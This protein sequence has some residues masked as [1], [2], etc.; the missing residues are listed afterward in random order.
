[1]L[2][3]PSYFEQ[4]SSSETFHDHAECKFKTNEV[5][6]DEEW[7]DNAIWFNQSQL[8]EQ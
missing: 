1:M 7:S 8:E 3:L 2:F 6:N 5:P 4:D